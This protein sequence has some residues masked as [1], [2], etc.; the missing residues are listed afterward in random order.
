MNGNVNIVVS[1]INMR[2]SHKKPTFVNIVVKKQR[3]CPMKDKI[4][5]I[6]KEALEKLGEQENPEPWFSP[7]EVLD[8]IVEIEQLK[9]RFER[10]CEVVN[11]LCRQ[12]EQLQRVREAAEKYKRI[13]IQLDF[14]LSYLLNVLDVKQCMTPDL[15]DGMQKTRNEL[16]QALA[17]KGK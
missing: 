1:I 11:E 10:E 12:R 14:D 5:E 16:Q 4:E 9:K 2:V 17:A 15:Y 3:R 7:E 8:L 6:K 13:A